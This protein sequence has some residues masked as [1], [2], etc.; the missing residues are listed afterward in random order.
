MPENRNRARQAFQ[1]R[2]VFP[3]ERSLAALS[4]HNLHHSPRTKSAACLAFAMLLA[5]ANIGAAQPRASLLA[6][7]AHAPITIGARPARIAFV[8]PGNSAAAASGTS[9]AEAVQGHR[10]SL[11]LGGV[12]AKTAPA[13]LYAVYL[14]LPE[15]AA[16]DG[17]GP[18]FVVSLNFFGIAPPGAGRPLQRVVDL[19]AT[20]RRLR[21]LG[22]LRPETTVTLAPG[23]KAGAG[24]AV[25]VESMEIRAEDLQ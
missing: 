6:I 10:L 1:D 12:V 7:A 3:Q 14:D 8:V 21:S 5:S 2:G 25:T 18:H 19:T 9:L 17:S 20:A 24:A 11:T 4:W 22:L 16:A 15:G 23:G 13:D